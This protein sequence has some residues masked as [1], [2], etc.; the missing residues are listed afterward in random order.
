MGYRALDGLLAGFIGAD[1]DGVFDGADEN[2]SVADFSGFG[3][4]DDGLDRFGSA[5]V[6]DNDFD[7]DFGEEI[8]GV[9]AAAID[10]GVAFLTAEAFDFRDGHAFDAEAGERVFDVFELE[11]LN[12]GLN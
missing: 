12:D 2:F 11:G 8:D 6:G 3:G 4:F 10:F 7:F 5:A 1:A 9:F